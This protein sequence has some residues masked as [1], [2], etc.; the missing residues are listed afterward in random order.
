MVF[1]GSKGEIMG[2]FKEYIR[3][4]VA[5]MRELTPAEESGA[6][7]SHISI[8]LEDVKAG[9]PRKGD[10]VARNPENHKDQWLVAAEYF[11]NN[12]KEK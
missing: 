12:F 11:K 4:N 3:T 2:N 5:E 7:G 8:S 10:M 9:S 1:I 6:I